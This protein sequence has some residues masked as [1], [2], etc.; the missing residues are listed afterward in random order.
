MSLTDCQ[1]YATSKNNS[2]VK[3]LRDGYCVGLSKCGSPNRCATYDNFFQLELG[4]LATGT[5]TAR[6][7][8]RLYLHELETRFPCKKVD[9]LG[10]NVE[11]YLP[12]KKVLWELKL[13]TAARGVGWNWQVPRIPPSRQHT[14]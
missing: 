3:V 1:V 9:R 7:I 13:I 11:T 8:D 2:P 4:G 6:I 14:S 12:A 10:A 5:W